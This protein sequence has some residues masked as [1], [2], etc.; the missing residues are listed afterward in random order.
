MKTKSAK[1]HSIKS[2]SILW[3][4]VMLGLMMLASTEVL[5]VGVGK[6]C[7]GLA[8]LQCDAGLFCQKKA[9]SCGIS[10]MTGTCA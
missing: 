6:I 2:Q 5:A 3:L 7:D 8:G 1:S 9:G 10:D 4:L